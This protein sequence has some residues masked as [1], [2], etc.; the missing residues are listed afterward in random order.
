MKSILK[1]ILI[2]TVVTTMT[3]GFMGCESKKTIEKKTKAANAKMAEKFK[4]DEMKNNPDLQ[5]DANG[6]ELTEEEKEDIYGFT[7][8]K[9][10]V[11]E[12]IKFE[13]NLDPKKADRQ[14]SNIKH[15]LSKEMKDM[16]T[17]EVERVKREKEK[18]ELVSLEV[19]TTI[20]H[21]KSE[22][23]GKYLYYVESIVGEKTNGGS[24]EKYLH[25]SNVEVIDGKYIVTAS[26]YI[27][28]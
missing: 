20:R 17:K 11:E 15:R 10:A 13:S 1:K 2:L 4:K 19:G 14:F 18:K 23:D 21:F 26:Q 27:K 8:A 9:K 12:Y 25:K 3:I 5:K 28:Q 16:L 6:N 7:E 22:K 24:V